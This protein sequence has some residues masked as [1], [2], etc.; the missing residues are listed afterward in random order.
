MS[1]LLKKQNCGVMKAPHIFLSMC[2]SRPK[3]VPPPPLEKSWPC[4][5]VFQL[6]FHNEVLGSLALFIKKKSERIA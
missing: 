1:A 2:L 5:A 3:D 6:L 4:F